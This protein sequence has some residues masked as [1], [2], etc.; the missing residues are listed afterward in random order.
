M[1]TF[2]HLIYKHTPLKCLTDLRLEGS[3]RGPGP[4]LI[5][6]VP[7]P[8]LRRVRGYFEPNNK[9]FWA[10][11]FSLAGRTIEEVDFATKT[12]VSNLAEFLNAVGT[13]CLS[14][15]VSAI[16]RPDLRRCGLLDRFPA[17]LASFHCAY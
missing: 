9:D 15:K 10:V 13:C 5:D 1:A 16:A 8:S 6:P 12:P 2:T 11:L 14:L 3:F 17:S 7:F 4:T